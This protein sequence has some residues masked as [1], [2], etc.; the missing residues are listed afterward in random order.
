MKK[1]LIKF[2]CFHFFP[3]I[4]AL[5]EEPMFFFK[6]EKLKLCCCCFEGEIETVFA[7][8][9]INTCVQQSECIYISI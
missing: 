2:D 6:Y 3:P 8:A 4:F 7:Q 1:N 9:N 5:F